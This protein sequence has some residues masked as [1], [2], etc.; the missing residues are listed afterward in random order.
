MPASQICVQENEG[1]LIESLV[2][3]V[4]DFTHSNDASEA[5]VV[6]RKQVD[7]EPERF[8]ALTH[9]PKHR[10]KRNESLLKLAQE[11]AAKWGYEHVV[12]EH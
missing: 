9:T 4:Q 10:A 12:D 6:Y 8:E 3:R 5:P 2:L 7:F 11:I 1:T